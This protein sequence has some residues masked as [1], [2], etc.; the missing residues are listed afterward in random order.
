MKNRIKNIGLFGKY[1]RDLN[2]IKSLSKNYSLFFLEEYEDYN[3]YFY[4]NFDLVIIYGYGKILKQ[5]FIDQV[6]GRIIN[7]HGGYLP[8]GRGIYPQLWST[9]NNEPT[10]FS[11]HEIDTAEIDNGPILYR[12]IVAYE[13]L[14]SYFTLFSRIKMKLEHYIQKNIDD[15]INDNIAKSKLQTDRYE[16]FKRKKSEDLYNKLPNGWNTNISEFVKKYKNLQ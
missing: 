5:D 6:K 1:I 4:Q 14:D 10:G 7:L 13:K 11:I 15:I 3:K 12:E 2:I 16:C 9:I 8:F